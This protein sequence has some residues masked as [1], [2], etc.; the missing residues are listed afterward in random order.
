MDGSFLFLRRIDHF[1][2]RV[3]SRLPPPLNDARVR[4]RLQAGAAIALAVGFLVYLLLVSNLLG[5][6]NGLATDL[7]YHPQPANPEIAI[8]S[9]DKKSLDELGAFPYPRA[10]YAA[11]LERLRATP[12][13]IVVFDVILA[14]PSSDDYLFADAMQR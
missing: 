3:T 5:P 12:P 6:L 7:L 9:I 10:V 13:R 14:Q 8:I 11:L 4:L 1:L 2:A